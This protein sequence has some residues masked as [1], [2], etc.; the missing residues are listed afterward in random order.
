MRPP[1]DVATRV[2]PDLSSIM[3]QMVNDPD[4]E[5]QPTLGQLR[6]ALRESKGKEAMEVESLHPQ[7]RI[8]LT[9]E[10]DGLIE[11]YGEDVPVIDFIATKA[12]EALSRVIEAAMVDVSLPEEPTLGVVR[13]AVAQGLAARLIGEGTIDLDEDATL[14]AEID[15]LI[16]RSGE[17]AVAEDFIR[18]E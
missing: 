2:S 16:R 7:D 4:R 8:S 11:E 15:E 14:L 6:A 10:L 18:F 13:Q 17:N 9:S 1:I 3:E 5:E 12:S